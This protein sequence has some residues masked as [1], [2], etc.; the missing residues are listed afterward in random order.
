MPTRNLTEFAKVLAKEVLGKLD[1]NP[2][3]ILKKASKFFST[4]WPQISYDTTT[5]EVKLEV[6]IYSEKDAVNTIDEIFEY[7][8]IKCKNK[9]IVIA[10]DE[11]QQILKY[12]EKNVEAILRSRIQHMINVNFIFSG[13]MKHLILAMFT[14]ANRPF[15]QSTEFMHLEKINPSD[16]IQFIKNFF[17]STGKSILE[18]DIKYIIEW[19]KSHTYYVQYICNKL[20]AMKT[21]K[22]TRHII[23]KLL[24]EILRDNE[25]AY[26]QYR[27]TLTIQQ[28]NVLYAIGKNNGVKMPTSNGFIKKY[29]LNTPS[30]VKSCINALIDKEF[31]Y[32][33]NDKYYVYD[34]F[35]EKWLLKA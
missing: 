24:I 7:L 2:I 26:Y 8:T 21:G 1:S 16:Y 29:N 12:P 22:I 4:F 30:T 17:I 13:S 15:Y 19:S 33:E 11:F 3:R 31:L 25:N 9:N 10:I 5:G 18:E 32:H 23:D 20:Y 27:N 14:H 6:A 28:W 35:F 34:V